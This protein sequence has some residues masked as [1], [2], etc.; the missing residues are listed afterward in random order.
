MAGWKYCSWTKDNFLY[1]LPKKWQFSF[2]AYEGTRLTGFCFASNKITGVYYIHLLFIASS[3]RG[4]SFGGKMIEHAKKI[5]LDNNIHSIELRCPETNQT[6]LAFYKKQG[7]IVKEI[8]QDEISGSEKDY[9]LQ[10]IF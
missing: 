9:Y 7:F 5:A 4:K 1:E 6:A 10:L 8:L 3:E 2:A